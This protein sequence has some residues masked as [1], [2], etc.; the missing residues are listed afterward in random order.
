MVSSSTMPLSA[1]A[2]M[3]DRQTGWRAFS[4]WRSSEASDR[5]GLGFPMG[6]ETGALEFKTEPFAQ[7]GAGKT[8]KRAGRILAIQNEG[9]GQQPLDGAGIDVGLVRYIAAFA[10][11]APISDQQMGVLVLHGP[12]SS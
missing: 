7:R 1:V 10:Q 4:A 2:A 8:V 6:Q 5:P 11:P 3:E 9:V 12:V